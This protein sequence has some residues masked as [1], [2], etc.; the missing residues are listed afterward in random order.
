MGGGSGRG[1]GLCAITQLASPF[2]TSYLA[3]LVCR[4]YAHRRRWHVPSRL[5]WGWLLVCTLLSCDTVVA[6]HSCPCPDHLVCSNGTPPCIC[7][8]NR[9]GASCEQTAYECAFERCHGPSQVCAYTSQPDRAVVCVPRSDSGFTV[10]R[11]ALYVIAAVS[12]SATVFTIVMIVSV[13]IRDVLA[14]K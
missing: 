1:V 2:M 11:L 10:S 8:S 13:G 9:F 6:T 3:P 4:F 7:Q 12:A 5:L 14:R